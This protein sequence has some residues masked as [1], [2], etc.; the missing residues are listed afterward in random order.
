MTVNIKI[1]ALIS[2]IALLS[3][4]SHAENY[5]KSV[6]NHQLILKGAE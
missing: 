5:E 1:V 2:F 3:G 6:I 4:N